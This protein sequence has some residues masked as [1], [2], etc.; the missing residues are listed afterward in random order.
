MCRRRAGNGSIELLVLIP[1]LLT[2]MWA[3]QWDLG[4]QGAAAIGERT[5]NRLKLNFEQRGR[6]ENRTATSFGKDPDVQTGLLRTRLGLTYEPVKRVKFSGMLQDA[7][8]PWYGVNAPNSV[9]DQADLHE[10]YVELFPAYKK[11]FGLTAGRM[12]LNYGDG[13]LIG[14]PQWSNLARTYDHARLYWR[15]QWAQIE[16]LVV[17]PVKV[18]IGEFNRPVPGDRIW[19]F[20]NVFPDIYQN[21]AEIYILHRDQ[22]RPGGFTGGLAK[23]KTDKLGVNTFGFRVNG[24]VWSGVKYNLEAALQKGKVGPA[25]LSACAWV[26]SLSRRWVVARKSLDVMGEYK[27]ASGSENPA[28][29]RHTGTFDQLYASNHDRFGHQ[30]LFGWRNMHNARFVS[31]LGLTKNFSLNFMYD[32][33]WLACLKDGIYNSSGKLIARSPSGSA[34]RHVGQETDVFGAYRY[35]HFLFGAGYGHFFS[36][37]FLQKTTPGAGPAYI[38]IFHTYSL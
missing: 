23:D 26:A 24:P 19:G 27:Y 6:Y 28:D 30:D 29:A 31:S 34:G 21:R 33:F 1:L 7:R 32:N 13:R 15:S 8:A 11:G 2:R 16:A 22:N 35:N 9:R 18:R 37:T 17:S 38:Y 3:Q 4:A 10:A 25:D 36:G 14:T 12:M 20:Y 5:N